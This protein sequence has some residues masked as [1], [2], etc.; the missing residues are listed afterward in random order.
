M[1][2]FPIK[3]RSLRDK[4]ASHRRSKSVPAG[5]KETKSRPPSAEALRAMFKMDG[6]KQSSKQEAE[7]EATKIEEIQRRLD[8][9][10]ITSVSTDHIRDVLATKFA[11]G[12]PTR[13]A[14]FIDLEQKAQA[15]IIVSHDPSVALLGA[16]NREGVTCYLDAL[17]FAMFSKL[18]A[19]ECML[20]ND[21]PLEDPKYKLVNLLRLWVNILRSGK[22]VHTDL[23]KLIQGAL[24][25]CGWADARLLEQ[26]D[27]SEAFVFLTETLQLPL[28]SLQ[29]DLFHQGKKEKDDH[30]VVFERLLNLAVPPDPE[31]RGV[32]LED[33]LEEYFNARVDVL[34]DSEEAKKSTM[35]DV[36]SEERP[37][38]SHH[39]TVRLVD[40]DEA[41]VPTSMTTSP[42]ETSPS[43]FVF[44]DAREDND[45]PLANGTAHE[46]GIS[47][48]NGVSGAG[49]HEEANGSQTPPP[50]RETST[51]VIRRVVVDEQGRP[52]GDMSNLQKARRKG[53]SVIKAV[54]IP[55]WQF[56]RLIPWHALTNTEP[57]NDTDVAMNFDQRPIV[58]ICLKRYAVNESGQPQRI[59]TFIDIPDSLRLPHFML[60]SGRELEK[61]NGLSTEYKL[62]LQSVVCHRGDSV[63]SGHYIAF[64]RVAPKLLKDNRKHSFDPP[65]DYEEAQ[66]VRFDDLESENR[67][68]FVDDIKQSLKEEMPYLLF[69]QVVPMVDMTCP[70]T[71]G[72]ETEPPSYDESKL[73]FDMASSGSLCDGD[74]SGCGR[75]AGHRR[76]ETLVAETPVRS[77]PPSIRLSSEGERLP[78]PFFDKN[79]PGW[80]TGSMAGDSRRPSIVCIDSE[81]VTPAITSDASSP[82]ISPNDEP[83]TSRLSRAASRFTLGRQSRSASQSGEGRISFSMTRLGGLMKT[84]KE[85]L[86]EP[87]GFTISTAGS[88]G[89]P[90]LD[91]PSKAP[92]SPLDGE[93]SPT[94][95]QCT[96]SKRKRG[97]SKDKMKH[98]SNGSQPERECSV[99]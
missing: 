3:F 63:Q 79:W 74:L 18:D 62:V 64:A 34:R 2:E 15:G 45:S 82:V 36:R 38:L 16:E 44:E 76:E 1:K 9:L 24:G 35:D 28:L 4:N 75:H 26:Q 25:D 50:P 10:S 60:A 97:K 17:L 39:D 8:R 70:S 32:K 68:V 7:I 48:Q 81:A 52:A 72:T 49:G 85:P 23:T 73:S 86:A 94:Q 80:N 31:G 22:L 95:P 83:T 93:K 29:V 40:G 99:M 92:E 42:T 46:C 33:C 27:T 71:E 43:T 98:G 84:S 90:N 54:T 53:S 77:K 87:N 30:K 65:P 14:E 47:Q 67:V 19:F 61:E 5:T 20:N 55:A 89:P 96:A 37:V 21:F 66:W 6:S 59:N 69:Y 88:A 78:R 91:T 13:A 57:Q 12:D 41:A 11:D 56:F 51:S 58:G